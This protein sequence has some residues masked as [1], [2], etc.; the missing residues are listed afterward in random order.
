MENLPDI[1]NL[2]DKGIKYA[3]RSETNLKGIELY[4]SLNKD[5][6]IEIIGSEKILRGIFSKFPLG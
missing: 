1:Y 5:L 4:F 6:N 2:A 3:M